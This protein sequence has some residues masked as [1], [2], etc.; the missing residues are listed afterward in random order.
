MKCLRPETCTDHQNLG[1]SSGGG[2]SVYIGGWGW[3][4]LDY[5]LQYMYYLTMFYRNG[6]VTY[7]YLTTALNLSNRRH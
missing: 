3:G 6:T 7:I 5:V 2:S 4:V 1:E